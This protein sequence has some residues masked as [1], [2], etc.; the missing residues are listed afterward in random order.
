MIARTTDVGTFRML[1]MHDEHSGKHL[2][3]LTWR[4]ISKEDGIN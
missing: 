3:I 2:A 1:N 4:R